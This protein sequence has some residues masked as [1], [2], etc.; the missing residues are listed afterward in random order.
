M[1]LHLFSRVVLQVKRQVKVTLLVLSLLSFVIFVSHFFYVF[2]MYHLHRKEA[3]GCHPSEG[4]SNLAAYAVLFLEWLLK[5][6]A[7]SGS[8]KQLIIK[9][10]LHTPFFLAFVVSSRTLGVLMN[11]AKQ[12]FHWMGTVSRYTCLLNPSC[13]T[14][15]GFFWI[16]QNPGLPAEG[17][18]FRHSSMNNPFSTVSDTT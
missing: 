7:G 16:I 3:Q 14:F 6:P 9:H 10:R 11:K 1:C 8:P 4:P 13:C 2:T 5:D 15:K 18:A 17:V 12:G